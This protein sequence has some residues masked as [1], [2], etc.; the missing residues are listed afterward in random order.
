MEFR[1]PAA[2]EAPKW[3]DPD[4]DMGAHA[5]TPANN[6]TVTNEYCDMCEP[7]AAVIAG[8][9]PA[10]NIIETDAISSHLI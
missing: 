10:A 3:A 8:A 6:A 7:P 5:A 4:G 1:P 9:L 2:A